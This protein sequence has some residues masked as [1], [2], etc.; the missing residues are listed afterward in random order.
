MP[1]TGAGMTII[2]EDVAINLGFNLTGEIPVDGNGE[3][4]FTGRFIQDASFRPP[5]GVLREQT[6]IAISLRRSTSLEA[7]IGREVDGIP[8]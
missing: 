2:D 1:D 6:A 8:R 5:G 7:G 4:Q 3:K